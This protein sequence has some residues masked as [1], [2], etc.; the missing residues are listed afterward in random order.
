MFGELLLMNTLP[1]ENQFLN[2]CGQ[3]CARLNAD[4]PLFGKQDWDC[5]ILFKVVNLFLLGSP[6]EHALRL[7]RVWVDDIINQPRWKDFVTRL[8][9]ELARYTIFVSFD[10]VCVAEYI[11]ARSRQSC[12]PSILASSLFLVSSM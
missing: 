11:I 8:T 12:S 4:T 7:Q 10:R 3:A 6:N 9:T 2:F 5:H 1:A